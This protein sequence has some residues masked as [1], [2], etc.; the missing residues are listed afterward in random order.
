MAENNI[1][2][3]SEGNMSVH[4]NPLNVKTNVVLS[5]VVAKP[6]MMRILLFSSS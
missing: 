2:S 3:I 6:T 1:I 4:F 5:T